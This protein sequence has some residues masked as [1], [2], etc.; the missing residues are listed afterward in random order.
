MCIQMEDQ[1][2]DEVYKYTEKLKTVWEQENENYP[3]FNKSIDKKQPTQGKKTPDII[4]LG[5]LQTIVK[6]CKWENEDWKS[7]R[8]QY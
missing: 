5:L 8:F 2:L 1:I 7:V 6:Q 4:F 3:K